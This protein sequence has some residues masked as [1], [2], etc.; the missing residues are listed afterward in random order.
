MENQGRALNS[1][2]RFAVD[3]WGLFVRLLRSEVAVAWILEVLMVVERNGIIW[4][5]FRGTGRVAWGRSSSQGGQE[6]LMRGQLVRETW[7][8]SSSHALPSHS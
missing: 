8:S 5:I 7:V 4:D 3:V 1:R 2:F 6:C